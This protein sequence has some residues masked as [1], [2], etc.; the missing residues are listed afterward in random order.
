MQSNM[1][2]TSALKSMR[3]RVRAMPLCGAAGLDLLASPSRTNVIIPGH[4]C[5]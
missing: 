4:L 5:P 1:L 3:P 2:K